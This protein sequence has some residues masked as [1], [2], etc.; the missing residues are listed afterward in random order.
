M[1]TIGVRILLISDVSVSVSVNI[2]VFTHVRGDHVTLSVQHYVKHRYITFVILI[3][4]FIQSND[5]SVQHYVIHRYITFVTLIVMFIQS[6]DL[7]KNHPLQTI[8]VV[9]QAFTKSKL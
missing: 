4:M 9:A 5:L 7:P 8:G 2:P 3:V 1:V 6:N